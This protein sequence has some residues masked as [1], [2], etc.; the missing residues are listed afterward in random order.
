[1]SVFHPARLTM[2]ASRTVIKARASDLA[3]G[4]GFSVTWHHR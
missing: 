1:M 4:T 2:V 3:H